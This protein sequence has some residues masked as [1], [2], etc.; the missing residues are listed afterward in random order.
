MPGIITSLADDDLYKLTMGQAVAKK[1][2]RLRVRSRFINRGGTTFPEGFDMLL[3]DE[4]E[5]LSQLRWTDDEL[6]LLSERQ[7][8]FLDP[9]FLDLLRG[10]YM[11]PRRVDIKLNDG[12]LEI[13]IEGFWYREIYWESKLMA[14]IS[15]LYF[16]T[17]REL[18]PRRDGVPFIA[19]DLVAVEAAAEQKGKRLLQ[20]GCATSEL[21]TRRRYSYDVHDAVIKGLLKGG[22]KCFLGTSNVHF[23]QKYD[24]KCFGTIAHEM[25]MVY[26]AIYGYRQ[27]NQMTLEDWVDVYQGNLGIAL[28]DTFT[29]KNF[30]DVFDSKYARLFDGLRHDSG[31]P[32][33]FGQKALAHYEKLGIDA[34]AKSLVFSDGL[35]VNKCIDIQRHFGNLCRV[36]Y[37]MGTYLT[38]DVGVI[39]LNMVIKLTEV[40]IN[41]KWVSTVKL[42]DNEGK[43]LGPENEVFACKQTLG[44]AA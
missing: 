29:T 30:F 7:G 9:A 11:D 17:M 4:L 27:A 32:I 44:L 31:D 20:A 15:E 13:E 26:A 42:S 3:K 24:I 14:I 1:F 43:E 34:L 6:K 10:I 28:T 38:N 16:R 25:F 18:A 8:K 40:F 2:P 33:A 5:H 21:G 35:N 39:A 36:G 37:G 41:G 12:A 23:S 22:G 19:D